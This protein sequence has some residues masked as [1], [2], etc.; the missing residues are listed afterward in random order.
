[1]INSFYLTNLDDEIYIFNH[2]I[3]TS[4]FIQLKLIFIIFVMLIVNITLT[5]GLEIV[6]NIIIIKYIK[7]YSFDIHKSQYKPE[8]NSDNNIV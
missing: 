4:Y 3:H 5:F 7:T 6:N 8:H 1:M 2:I